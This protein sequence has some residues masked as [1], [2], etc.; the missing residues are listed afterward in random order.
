[1]LVNGVDVKNKHSVG[2]HKKPCVIKGF[3]NAVGAVK[4]VD[5]VKSAL[6]H[7]KETCAK[8]GEVYGSEVIANPH[9]ELLKFFDVEQNDL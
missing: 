7:G 1:M 3:F 4:V 6:E 2:V 5:A 8:F 9:P